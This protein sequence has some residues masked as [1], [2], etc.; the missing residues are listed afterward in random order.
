MPSDV[1][2]EG[3][4]LIVHPPLSHNRKGVRLTDSD[5]ENL[6]H[7]VGFFV[8]LLPSGPGGVRRLLLYRTRPS[9]STY[10][11]FPTTVKPS[12]GNSTPVERVPG[13]RAPLTPRLAQLL[14]IPTRRVGHHSCRHK[15]KMEQIGIEPTASTLRTWR[16]P[17]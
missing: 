16:S 17:S 15:I 2:P 1:R 9:T 8:P 14:M 5:R 4:L 10:R 7:T 3:I 11:R 13:Y 6:Q 12:G